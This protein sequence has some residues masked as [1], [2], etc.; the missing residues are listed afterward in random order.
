MSARAGV[1][2]GALVALALL[3]AT[4]ALAG[5]PPAMFRRA[6][7]KVDAQSVCVLYFDNNTGDPSYEPLKKGL[8]DMM[9]TDLAGVEGLTV[10]E[11]SRLQ[12]VVGELKLQKTSLFDAATAQKV[13]KLVGARYAVT[14]AIAAVAPKIRL[15]VRLI[16]VKTGEVV[17]ADKV[18]G[19]ADDFFALQERLSSVFVI[20]LGRQVAPPSKT[21]A[22][23]LAT[24]LDYGKALELAD[25]GDPQA[26]A[27]QMGEVVAEAPDFTLAK[28][29]YAELMQRVYAAKE[30]RASGLAE[31]E[32]RLLARCDEEL[33][34][35]DV[36]SLRGKKLE[37]Y[38][39]YRVMRGHFYLALIQR[40]TNSRSPFSPTPIPEEAREQV[41]GW[42]VA[43]WDNQ[44]ALS[45]ELA[46]VRSRIPSF[47]RADDA[48]VQVARELGLGSS[49]AHLAFMSPQTVNRGL[50]SF[51]LTGKPDLF[52][53]VRPAV[54]PSLAVLDASY[55]EPGLALLDEALADIA[56]HEK[57]F[58]D[59]ETIRTLD[60]YGECLLALG[61]PVEAIARWQKV[62][63]DYPTASE[64][65]KIEEKIK[66]VLATL[67]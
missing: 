8:A 28:T 24:V 16:E 39:G 47:A 66:K 55:A 7:V 30:K 65:G 35:K 49:P 44:R 40:V 48:D 27:K 57:R 11:R 3:V 22:K 52:A 20:G 46:A 33:A 14:G 58:K 2:R 37:R 21:P 43:F 26:A 54:A 29:R 4:P 12:D 9:V 64:F 38:I 13:G 63:D 5:Y 56:A 34:G 51:A 67:K 6:P 45:G 18:V 32:T 36:K 15:D 17:L 62:L 53:S 10:V 61:R 42:M 31:A 50:A 60:L 25:S 59:R 19:V 1:T 41:K 23:K